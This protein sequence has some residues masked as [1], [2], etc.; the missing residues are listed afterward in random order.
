MI[1]FPAIDILG[2]QAVRLAQGS[3]SDVT[4]YNPDPV[5]QASAFAEAGA[6]W[7]HIVDLDGARTGETENDRTIARILE[8]TDIGIEVGG[9]IRTLETIGRYVEAGARRI[10][11]GTKLATDP[12]FVEEAVGEFGDY[13]VAG[14]DAKDGRVAVRGWTESGGLMADDLVSRLGD[15]GIQH[16]V[17]TDIS[18]DGMQTGIDVD[19]YVELAGIAGFPVVASGGIATMDDIEA[20]AAAGEAIEGAIA[21]KAIYENSLDLSEALGICGRRG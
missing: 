10:V 20:L 7:I 1:L 17:Y 4:L 2:G 6:E 16:L 9:G 11:L 19:R 21:G 5:D 3:Y 8:Q 13:L 18:R 15:M 12:A 14:I